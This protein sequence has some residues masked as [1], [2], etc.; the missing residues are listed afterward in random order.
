MQPRAARSRAW[1][2]RSRLDPSILPDVVALAN[3][4]GVADK[5]GEALAAL[6]ATLEYRAEMAKEILS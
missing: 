5:V 3:S 2:L 6:A 1:Q 4:T